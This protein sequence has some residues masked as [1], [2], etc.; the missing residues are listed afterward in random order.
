[1]SGYT[2]LH[3]VRNHVQG[4]G[5]CIFFYDSLIFKL[6]RNLSRNNKEMEALSIKIIISTQH[7]HISS[8]GK[9]FE[10]YFK[11]LEQK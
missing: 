10:E 5:I 3:Q 7:G 11:M 8:K 1:M 4:C 2:S 6:R 9:I